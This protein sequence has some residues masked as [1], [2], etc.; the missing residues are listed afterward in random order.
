MGDVTAAAL[1]LAAAGARACGETWARLVPARAR[2]VLA[3]S[4]LAAAGV[5]ALANVAALCGRPGAGAAAYPLRAAVAGEKIAYL[6]AWCLWAAALAVCVPPLP[7]RAGGARSGDAC[8]GDEGSDGT[9]GADAFGKRRGS[10]GD[11]RVPTACGAAAGALC[12]CAGLLWRTWQ[13]ALRAGAA[14][15]SPAEAYAVAGSCAMGALLA[16]LVVAVR[17]PARQGLGLLAWY[18]GGICAA[19]VLVLP[20]LRDAAS[21]QAVR[22][23]ASGGLAASLLAMA[24]A[25]GAAFAAGRRAGRADGE[26]VCARGSALGEAQVDGAQER[27]LRAVAALSGADALT[28][29][30]RA[31][32]ALTVAGA[33][34]V[35]IAERLGIRPPTVG[36]YRARAYQKL[37]VADKDGLR[38]ACAQA[39]P[40]AAAQD[41]ARGS[42]SLRRAGVSGLALLTA[43]PVALALAGTGACALVAPG[44]CAPQRCAAL[45]LL[46][47]AGALTGAG[48]L[49][50][51]M[52]ATV[53][54]FLLL[55]PFDLPFSASS[56][57]SVRR[58]AGV[59]LL[60]A[61]A[62]GALVAL[63]RRRAAFQRQAAAGLEGFEERAG[64]LM[65]AKGLSDTAA[66]VGVLG[67]QGLSLGATAR[68][69]CLAPSTVAAYRTQVYRAFAVRGCR[70]LSQA[71]RRGLEWARRPFGS[72]SFGRTGR[73]LSRPCMG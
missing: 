26:A 33:S 3:A 68:A 40:A 45:V 47:L 39:G 19:E 24:C 1:A 36:T 50:L 44:A 12:L 58:V 32:A 17:R 4:A 25:A 62:T 5:L 37:G 22:A 56:N 15:G 48:E 51:A 61:L 10:G 46:A 63:R 2:R 71:V 23:V 59:V 64:Y 65:R 70:A 42:S 55:A 18:S 14:G 13:A 66:R 35:E 11:K 53:A 16:S 72:S 67:A 60:V 27:A 30:E 7:A 49:A 38:E 9:R 31:V 41:G 28:E 34:Q 6:A 8:P 73:C 20:V 29:C 69:L 43:L 21:V 54:V 57:L 52:P